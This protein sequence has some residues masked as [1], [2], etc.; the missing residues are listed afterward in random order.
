MPKKKNVNIKYTSREFDS[1][2]TDLIDHVQRSY[3]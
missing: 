2:K 3:F 1:I